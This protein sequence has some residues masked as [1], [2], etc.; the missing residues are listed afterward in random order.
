MNTRILMTTNSFV[1]GFAGMVALFAPQELLAMLSA[2][3]TNP[4]PVIIQLMGALYFSFALINWAAKGNILGGIYSRPISIGN[5]SHF[6]VGTLVLAKHQ[7]SG[8]ANALLFAA[9]IA[10]AAF[11]IVFGWLVFVHSGIAGKREAEKK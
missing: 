11:A 1:L 10:Y 5:F 4:L 9:M 2:P 8:G 7:L 6:T 3:V